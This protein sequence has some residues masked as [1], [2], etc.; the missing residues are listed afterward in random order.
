MVYGDDCYNY[1]GLTSGWIDGV[2]ED[3]L[4]LHDFA[5]LVPVVHGA[6]GIMTEWSGK[7]LSVQSAGDVLACGDKRLHEILTSRLGRR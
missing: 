7:E 6:G 1:A 3:M 2:V 4:K 5:A